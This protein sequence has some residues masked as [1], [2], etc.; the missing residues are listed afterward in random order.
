MFSR[1]GSTRCCSEFSVPFE[2]GRVPL[3]CSLYERTLFSLMVTRVVI[4]PS[5]DLEGLFPRPTK[6]IQ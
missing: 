6:L 4:V 2:S 5:L 1:T 3:I